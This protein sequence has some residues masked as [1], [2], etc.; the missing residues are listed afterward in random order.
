[1]TDNHKQ[2]SGTNNIL[3]MTE[4]IKMVR[5]S[6]R[7]HL[8]WTLEVWEPQVQTQGEITSGLAECVLCQ[9]IQSSIDKPSPSEYLY[10]TDKTY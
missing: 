1:M 3:E 7:L 6:L 10:N 8:G 2:P 9:N 5:S 4:S